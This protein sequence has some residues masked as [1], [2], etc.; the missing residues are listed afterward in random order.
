MWDRPRSE[1]EPVSPALRGRFFTNGT[2]GKSPMSL[3]RPE[4]EPAGKKGGDL[5]WSNIKTRLASSLYALSVLLVLSSQR[6]F[7]VVVQSPRHVWLFVTPWT[8]ACQGPSVP[9]HLPEFAQVHVYCFNRDEYEISKNL[10]MDSFLY[11]VNQTWFLLL[12]IKNLF[13]FFSF[14]NLDW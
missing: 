8:A 5:Q 12:A 13:F 4:V 6:W 1:I 9:H 14:K 7:V 11:L 2:L 10:P 3:G